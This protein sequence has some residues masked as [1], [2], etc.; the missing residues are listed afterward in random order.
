MEKA[1]WTLDILAV[2][3]VGAAANRLRGGAIRLPGG[4]LVGRLIWT[5][6]VVA[7]G[8]WH[9]LPPAWCVA[10]ALAGY[11]STTIGQF[12]ALDMG[13][14][15]GL[16]WPS[17]ALRITAYGAAR[18]L[19]LALVLGLAGRTWWPLALATLAAL[20]AY[21]I[22][23]RLPDAALRLPYL[24]RGTGPGPARDPPQLA[25][26]LHGAALGLALLASMIGA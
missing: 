20:P 15:S 9:A 23:W 22:P 25:E 5:A 1:F 2:A 4:D 26:A 18:A 17:A 8:A 7:I 24:G 6:F 11:A 10:L 16:P 3:L 12:G 21:D 19:P 14:R 13:Y